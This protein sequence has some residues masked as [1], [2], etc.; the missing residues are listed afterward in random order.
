MLE[1]IT[2]SINILNRLMYSGSINIY[3]PEGKID[4]TG[5]SIIGSLAEDALQKYNARIYFI[6]VDC[7]TSK[8][9]LLHNSF[10]ATSISRIM[11]KNSNKK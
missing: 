11:L 2:N 10:E 6:G 5:F 9:G 8:Q 3:V 7:M 4:I 1:V